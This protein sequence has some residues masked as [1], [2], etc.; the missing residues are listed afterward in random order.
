MNMANWETL[1]NLKET[2]ERLNDTN[3]T[4]DSKI[5]LKLGKKEV[6]FLSMML[7]GSGKTIIIN[8]D[9]D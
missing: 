7:D 9:T 3:V 5:V 8:L 2:L 1:K 4:E 6:H